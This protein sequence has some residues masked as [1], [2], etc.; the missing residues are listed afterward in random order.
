MATKNQSALPLLLLGGG[1]LLLSFRTKASKPND[2]VSDPDHDFNDMSLPRG[3]RN[4]N[5]G[6][7]ILTDIDWDGKIPNDENSDGQFEQFITIEYGIQAMIEN[8]MTYINRGTDDIISIITTWSPPS[9]DQDFSTQNYIDFVSDRTGVEKNMPWNSFPG[10]L[11]P[12]VEAMT[13]F[14]NGQPAI[15]QAQYNGGVML[16]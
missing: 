7:I 6:N 15:T 8:L 11:W 5:P 14:E 10:E 13:Y 16:L 9:D 12:L 1:L 3:I 2:F 4:N